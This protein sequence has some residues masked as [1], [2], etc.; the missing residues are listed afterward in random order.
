MRHYS[1]Q[2]A[3]RNAEHEKA[4]KWCEKHGIK[5]DP[6]LEQRMVT[7]GRRYSPISTDD[8][9][10]DDDD[11]QEPGELRDGEESQ[12]S[13]PNIKWTDEK[14]KK[15][16]SNTVKKRHATGDHA[17]SSVKQRKTY[18]VTRRCLSEALAPPGDE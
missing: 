3:H 10:T 13:F 17:S 6:R 5:V 1:N 12:H 15:S 7:N 11:E 9:S 2:E 16:Q 14:E 4:V 8:D 18:M